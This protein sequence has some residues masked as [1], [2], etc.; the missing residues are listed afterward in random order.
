[1]VR[2]GIGK[3]R[4]KYTQ[5]SDSTVLTLFR[6]QSTKS[7]FRFDVQYYLGVARQDRKLVKIGKFLLQI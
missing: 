5:V 3:I 2:G 1:M 4:L 6:N 7:R